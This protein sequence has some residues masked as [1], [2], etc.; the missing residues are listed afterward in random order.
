MNLIYWIMS[1]MLFTFLYNVIE[2]DLDRH[3]AL[4]ALKSDFFH[5]KK[6]KNNEISIYILD[7][8][9]QLYTEKR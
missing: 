3:K 9:A 5:L 6:K 8:Q 2:C 7:L 4:I 1:N